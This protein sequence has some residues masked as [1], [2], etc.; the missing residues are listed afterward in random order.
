MT[1]W[2]RWRSRTTKSQRKLVRAARDVA[3]AILACV[4]RSPVHQ[5]IGRVTYVV[6]D[7]LC[8]PC[9]L[10]AQELDNIRVVEGDITNDPTSL[11]TLRDRDGL[12]RGEVE[13]I[14][15]SV[16]RLEAEEEV[17]VQAV[18][19]TRTQLKKDIQAVRDEMVYKVDDLDRKVDKLTRLVEQM[20]AR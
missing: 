15:E 17:M 4:Y 3:G 1:K 5:L 11:T 12:G 20:I 8:R 9:H 13:Y 6:T 19:S 18:E 2:W 14:G 10:T 16:R 7:C